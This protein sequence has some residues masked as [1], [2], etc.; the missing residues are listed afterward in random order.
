TE[1]VSAMTS[2][3]DRKK[4]GQID[5]VSPFGRQHPDLPFQGTIYN[6]DDDVELSETDWTHSGEV[7]AM[8]SGKTERNTL[9]PCRAPL[10]TLGVNK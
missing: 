7:Y 8:S 2:K 9:C 1:S 10:D 5:V 3:P 4:T 6:D